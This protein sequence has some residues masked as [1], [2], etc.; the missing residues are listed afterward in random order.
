[1]SVKETLFNGAVSGALDVARVVKNDP[2]SIVDTA[3]GVAREIPESLDQVRL[4]LAASGTKI[5]NLIRETTALS[6]DKQ[7]EAVGKAAQAAGREVAR[8]AGD[9]AK[10]VQANPLVNDAVHTAVPVLTQVASDYGFTNVFDAFKSFQEGKYAEGLKGVGLGAANFAA[11]WLGLKDLF[12][13]LPD[14]LSRGDLLGAGLALVSGVFS[15]CSGGLFSPIRSVLFR[16]A[17]VALKAGTREAFEI[18]AKEA[19]EQVSKH[20]ASDAAK[21]IGNKS[22]QEVVSEA[23]ETTG[24]EVAEALA[25]KVPFGAKLSVNNVTQ[26]A[27]EAEKI[28]YSKTKEATE[29]LL[30]SLEVDTL[31]TDLV[32][33]RLNSIATKAAGSGDQ[34][35]KELKE[36]GV[37]DDKI[38]QMVKGLRAQF[39]EAGRAGKFGSKFDDELIQIYTDAISKEVHEKLIAAGSKKSFD[40]GFEAGLEEALRRRGASI[41]A[42]GLKKLKE[43]AGRGFDKGLADGVRETVE[44]AV[45]EAFERFRKQRGDEDSRLASTHQRRGTLSVQETDHTAVPSNNI[46]GFGV[47]RSSPSDVVTAKQVGSGKFS[48]DLAAAMSN[49]SAEGAKTNT[50]LAAA[51]DAANN[52]VQITRPTAPTTITP[53][54]TSVATSP[55]SESTKIAASTTTPTT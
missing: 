7:L 24:K 26:L 49:A 35:A 28:A 5:T 40:E 23:F 16:S 13:R 2:K 1:M 17:Q 25:S 41:D 10:Q 3:T 15:L 19:A 52:I 31:I 14:S 39:S 45:R 29:K 44:R 32:E 6:G 38:K 43:S 9:L 51:R 46:V 20:L 30:K 27:K 33:G 37:A 53:T 47:V 54:A 36:F 12:V 21:A 8:G 4:E 55:T 50:E 22:V 18:F 48:S 34:L 11:E 42:E